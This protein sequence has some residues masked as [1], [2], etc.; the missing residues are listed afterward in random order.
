LNHP[1]FCKKLNFCRI[2]GK[3]L[4]G[5]T[6]ELKRLKIMKKMSI[7]ALKEKK[8]LSQAIS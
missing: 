5:K 6:G 7:L 8:I 3:A 2:C 4:R 1:N